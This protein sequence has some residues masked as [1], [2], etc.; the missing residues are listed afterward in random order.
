MRSRP[1]L[2]RQGLLRVGKP[3][4]RPP[5]LCSCFPSL[6]GVSSVAACRISVSSAVCGPMTRSTREA[7]S[8]GGRPGLAEHSTGFRHAKLGVS[9]LSRLPTTTPR[10][11]TGNTGDTGNTGNTRRDVL[12]MADVS[13]L[14][15]ALRRWME[16]PAKGGRRRPERSVRCT[17][18]VAWGPRELPDRPGVRSNGIVAGPTA[19]RSERQH[20]Q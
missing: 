12:T 5:I 4:I 13:S 15:V 6:K 16:E 3:E 11:R 2:R 10:H 20:R 19:G 8:A 18:Q 7:G 1:R 17:L 14:E 9:R